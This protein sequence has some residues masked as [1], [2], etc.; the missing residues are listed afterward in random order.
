MWPSMTL[1]WRGIHQKTWLKLLLYATC[2]DKEILT[3][4][5][6]KTCDLDTLHQIID[7]VD[8]EECGKNNANR[9]LGGKNIAAKVGFGGGEN[10]GGWTPKC[11]ICQ[12]YG[13]SRKDCT[14]DKDSLW[15]EH[16]K[17]RRHNTSKWCPKYKKK[18]NP[19]ENP[20]DKKDTKDPKLKPRK[21]G[22][23]RTVKET[24]KNDEEPEDEDDEDDDTADLLLYGCRLKWWL[25]GDETDD[26]LDTSSDPEMFY[27]DSEDEPE[28]SSGNESGYFTPPF[29]PAAAPAEELLVED[30]VTEDEEEPIMSDKNIYPPLLSD[31]EHSDSEENVEYQEVTA[32]L[33][34]STG[35]GYGRKY[36]HGNSNSIRIS[37]SCRI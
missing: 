21:K 19:K 30:F 15:C 5:L 17:T 20:K 35:N 12:A 23:A 33:L 28:D 24:G 6:A 13:H 16:C 10:T 1:I 2:T 26:D 31:S 27:L 29:T 3:K 37:A 4:I 25:V 8:A 7:F 32:E 14:V 18:N 11:F 9:L 34:H 36:F 22:Q